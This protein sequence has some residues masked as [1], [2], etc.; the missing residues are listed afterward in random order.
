M[1]VSGG[2]GVVV[3]FLNVTKVYSGGVV[4]LERL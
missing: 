4:A 3:E 1:S 2:S